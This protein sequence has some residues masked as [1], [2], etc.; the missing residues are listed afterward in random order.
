MTTEDLPTT[1]KIGDDDNPY[2]DEE[3]VTVPENDNTTIPSEGT[4]EYAAEMAKRGGA[5]D[6]EVAQVLEAERAK[7]PNYVKPED[8]PKD[9][10]EEPKDEPKDESKGETDETVPDLEAFQREATENEGKLSDASIDKLVEAGIGTKEQIE[11]FVAEQYAQSTQVAEMQ[12]NSLYTEVGGKDKYATM[13][14]WAKVNMSDSE[15]LNY[16]KDVNSG[17]YDTIRRAIGGLK[18]KYTKANGEPPK[19]RV[20]GNGNAGASAD[21]YRSQ[22][23]VSADMNDPRYAK[24]PA[25]QERVF[26]KLKRSNI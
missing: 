3:T 21:V 5:S 11:K 7:D 25:F 6:E 26:Q 18:S 20:R 9:E 1:E 19:Q 12:L 17:D 24:D 10:P 14:E 22:A 8:E 23:Q 15:K 4:P 16:N 2:N 13:V